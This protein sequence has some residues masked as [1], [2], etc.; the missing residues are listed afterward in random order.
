MRT[1]RPCVP[2]GPRNPKSAAPRLNGAPSV[3]PRLRPAFRDR[4]SPS[5]PVRSA[6]THWD[7]REFLSRLPETLSV[8]VETPRGSFVKRR[9]DG[10]LDFVSPLPCPYNYGAAVGHLGG[11][12]DPLDVVLLGALLPKGQRVD[13]KVVGVVGF[14]DAGCDDHKVICGVPPSA[15]M[16]LGLKLFFRL[17]AFAKRLL[18]R[19]RAQAGMTAYLG[20]Y[21]REQPPESGEPTV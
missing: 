5:L 21:M 7:S 15:P 12:G 13:A 16:T 3:S 20:V 6:S 1:A 2:G 19:R 11:D 14:I 4:L 17:Y 10:T 9:A 18:N 8:E